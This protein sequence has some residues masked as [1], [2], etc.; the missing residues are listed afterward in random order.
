MSW[1]LHLLAAQDMHKA[2]SVLVRFCSSLLDTR[3][4]RKWQQ[5]QAHGL[6]TWGK[7]HESSGF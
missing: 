3:G 6:K 5:Y 4:D 2:F 7:S 1:F